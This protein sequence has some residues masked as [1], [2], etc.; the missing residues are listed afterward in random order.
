MGGGGLDRKP[1]Q[2]VSGVHVV[3]C[4]SRSLGPNVMLRLR[5][6]AGL[7]GRS[8]PLRV[9]VGGGR[10]ERGGGEKEE[11]VA[12]ALARVLRTPHGSGAI[13]LFPLHPAVPHE[14]LWEYRNATADL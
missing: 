7:A 12:A 2:G 1:P 6:C 4:G 8:R 5:R 9:W 3:S 10:G 14:C 13:N 11:E